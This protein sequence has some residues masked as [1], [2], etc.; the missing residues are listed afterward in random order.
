MRVPTPGSCWKCSW[1][2]QHRAAP[3]LCKG[4]EAR[5]IPFLS[6]FR[7]RGV[8][9]IVP[10]TWR[11]IKSSRGSRRNLFFSFSE[12]QPDSNGSFCGTVRTGTALLLYPEVNSWGKI[13][14]EVNSC[15]WE[16]LSS[17]CWSSHSSFPLTFPSGVTAIYCSQNW[18]IIDFMINISI[19]K[20]IPAFIPYKFHPQLPPKANPGEPWQTTLAMDPPQVFL[21]D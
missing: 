19:L 20:Q 18:M 10:S 4:S 21:L 16:P 15:R 9:R 17:P 6:S 1:I 3:A 14:P 13:T 7:I 12:P 11:N 2:T 5:E 8:L